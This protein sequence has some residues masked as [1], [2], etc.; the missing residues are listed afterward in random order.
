MTEYRR[1]VYLD[2]DILVQANIDRMFNCGTFCATCRQSDNFFNAGVLVVEPSSV[3]L[4]DIL[5]NIPKV[6]SFDDGDQGFFN[7]Y[8]DDL[9]YSPLFNWSDDTKQQQLMRLPLGLNLD[10]GTFYVNQLISSDEIHNIR[11]V[12]YSGFVKPWC[13]WNNF[14]F[15][16]T[17][18]WT[19]VR[20]R[21]PQHPSSGHGDTDLPT[22]LALVLAPYPVLALLFVGLKF[23]EQ[24]SHRYTSDR[25]PSPLRHLLSHSDVLPLPILF[26][27]YYLAYELIVPTT[28]MPSQAGYVFLLWS[29]FFFLT[30]TRLYH[31]LCY[32][33]PEKQPP[34]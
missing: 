1:I 25:D 23:V 20:E 31:F 17:W 12:H 5:W 14:L 10:T 34:R 26:I 30:F 24:Y 19:A 32:Q 29:N 16:F 27:S 8:F 4:K 33:L 18:R 13:W 9:I 3:T 11:I 2:S 28:M 7:V 22:H 6:P 21:L 15:D